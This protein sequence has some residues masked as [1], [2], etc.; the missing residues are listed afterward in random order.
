[1]HADVA[2]DLPIGVKGS[3][4]R[5]A[6]FEIGLSL[7]VSITHV[8]RKLGARTGL[9]DNLRWRLMNSVSRSERTLDVRRWRNPGKILITTMVRS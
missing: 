5:R 2:N 7:V 3:S 1:V 4:V 8:W 6:H 9:E